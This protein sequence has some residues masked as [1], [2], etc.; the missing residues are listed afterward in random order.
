MGM[1]CKTLNNLITR[2]QNSACAPE[3]RA[4]VERHKRNLET[5][6]EWNI[7]ASETPLP[8]KAEIIKG[9]EQLRRYIKKDIEE[10]EHDQ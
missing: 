8:G 7:W 1:Y 2:R 3:K 9:I 6:R 5:L 10:L 4:I